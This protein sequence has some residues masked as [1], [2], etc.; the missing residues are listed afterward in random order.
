MAEAEFPLGE[1]ITIDQGNQFQPQQVAEPQSRLGALAPLLLGLLGPAGL[2]AGGVLAQGNVQKR[3]RDQVSEAFQT[4]AN[5]GQ[6]GAQESLNNPAVLLEAGTQLLR[7]RRTAAQGQL[8]I[9]QANNITNQNNEEFQRM[10]TEERSLRGEL[11]S[12][13]AFDELAQTAVQF[14]IARSLFEEGTPTAT[15]QLAR[16]LEKTIDPTGVV[17]PSDFELILS[18]IGA[19]DRIKDAFRRF[20]EGGEIP[21]ELAPDIMRTIALVAQQRRAQFTE[22]TAGRFRDMALANRVRPSQ[23]F[24]DPLEGLGIDELLA[25]T[26]KAPEPVP[27]ESDFNFRDFFGGAPPTGVR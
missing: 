11:E 20:Q 14:R 26:A 5:R 1:E 21:P 4:A 9:D 12:T 7:D 8:M 17:R 25:S 18:G 3:G 15:T 22:R 6:V 27:D 16:V 10:V 24:F 23:V 13:F 19:S 2:V